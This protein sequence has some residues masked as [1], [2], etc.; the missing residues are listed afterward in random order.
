MKNTRNDSSPEEGC[1]CDHDNPSKVDAAPAVPPGTSEE[2][3]RVIGM[4]CSEEVAAIER[5]VKPLAGVSGVRANIMASSVTVYQ[6][7]SIPTSALVAAINFSGVQVQAGAVSEAGEKRPLSLPATLVVASG[8]FTSVGILLQWIG[9]KSGWQPDLAFL[10]AILSGGWLIVPKALRSLRAFSLDMNVLMTVAVVGA[11]AIGEHAEGAAVVFLFALSELLE[12][13]S[14]GRARR[15]IQAL[16]QLAPEVALVKRDGN[17][18]E[19]PAKEV[20]SGETI[21][22]KSGQ[23]VP[24][25]GTVLSGA[26]A[27]NQAPITGESMPVEKTQ[28]DSVFAGTINGEGSLEVQTTKA[29]GDT[30]LARIIKLVEEAQQQKAPA[31]RFVDVFAKY[32][33]PAVMVLALLV[34]IIPPLLF[35]QP[36]MDWVYR[37][38]V[39]LVIACPC[40]LVIATPVSIVSGLTAMAK[41]GVLIKGGAYLEALGGLRALAVDKTGTITEGKPR[42]LEVLPFNSTSK[43]EIIRIAAAIDTHSTHPLAQAVVRYA[44]EN[45]TVFEAATDYQAKTGRGAEATISAHSYFVGNHRFAHELGVCSDELEAKLAQIEAKAQSVVVVGHRPHAGCE[46]EVLGILAIGDA[47]RPNA[48]EAIRR[49]HEAGIRK[50]VM[51]SGD[52]A[53]TADAI[54]KQAGIDEAQGDLLPDHKIDQVKKLAAEFG[55]VGM[56]GDGV[57]DA[58]ALAA[59]NVGIAM[60]AAGTD[61]AIETADVALMRDDLMMVSEAIRLGRRTLGM[62]RFNIGF[63]LGIKAIFLALALLGMTS[64]WLAILADTGATLLVIANALR[65]LRPSSQ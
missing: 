16:M 15:A 2:T 59:A 62:I 38:L 3:F 41:R 22:I 52:N 11:V 12:S 44:E 14:V 48:A 57:N 34:G 1:C 18:Q 35:G 13:W 27:I 17:I 20:N 43:E 47:I 5:A 30:T 53:R 28:G 31:Q 8:I 19:V 6:D 54:A 60:G 25:D 26:S 65:L 33:T 58:P 40:A 56:I 45:G 50:V 55:S 49:I 9:I 36:G 7:G 29:A 51:L 23:R 63:A 61:T 24:L 32:Y 37:A 42:V 21:V 64:L 46:G 10:M 39:L 4:D